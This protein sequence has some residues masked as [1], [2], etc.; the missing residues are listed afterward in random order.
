[1]LKGKNV[2][3]Q[4][5]M[6]AAGAVVAIIVLSIIARSTFRSTKRYSPEVLRSVSH[7]MRDAARMHT[8]SAQDTNP[9]MSLMHI[10]SAIAYVKA[11]RK[12]LGAKEVGKVAKINVEEFLYMLEEQ[13]QAAVQALMTTCPAAV[14]DNDNSERTGWLG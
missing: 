10:D 9:V 1:M 13:Q 5:A 4:P 14:P 7:L 8:M 12:I 11:A 2:I 3:P 6:W